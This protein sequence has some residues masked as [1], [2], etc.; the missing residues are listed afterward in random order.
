VEERPERRVG[1]A[2]VVFVV[3]TLGEV[4]RGIGDLARLGQ[5]GLVVVAI[6]HLA[7][8]AEPD[9]AALTQGRAHGDRKAAFGAGTRLL[10]GGDTIGNDDQAAQ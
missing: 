5:G 7:A 4:D 2:D 9:A 6:Q 8:P 1:E 3:V 10:Y